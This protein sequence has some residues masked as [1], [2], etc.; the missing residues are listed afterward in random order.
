MTT[1]WDMRCL[2][3]TT[4]GLDPVEWTDAGKIRR[5]A[6]TKIERGRADEEAQDQVGTLVT[7]IDNVEGTY[8]PGIAPHTPVRL[9]I[10]RDSTAA[11]HPLF[12][13]LVES[14]PALWPAPGD[15]IVELSA[16]DGLSWLA[17]V[18][19][20]IER[21]DELPGDRIAAVLDAAGWP[22]H[23][24][25]LDPGVVRFAEGGR[26]IASDALSALREAVRVE[27]GQIFVAGDGTLTFRDR[28]ARLGAPQVARFGTGGLMMTDLS[29][30]YDDFK[31]YT[32]GRAE[33]ADG[34]VIK[35][36]SDTIDQFGRRTFEVRDLPVSHHEAVAAI[37]W[38]VVCYDEPTERIPRL[39]I[40]GTGD[41]AV[42]DVQISQ[43]LGDMV[44]IVHE[45][46]QLPLDVQVHIE[47]ETH[48]LMGGAWRTVYQLS[49]YFGAGPW[50]EWLADDDE[51]T[52]G[53]TWLSD[54]ATE[55]AAWA[56]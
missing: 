43:Q 23:L 47:R 2:L 40:N 36:E 20:D 27:Q 25:D 11:W 12:T 41:D 32:V 13:G 31:L 52:D 17:R 37:S 10:K 50:M 53:G 8:S 1:P 9:E 22:A 45:S 28:H 33:M 19:I 35:F 56:P 51:S 55:G 14:A 49:P 21:P 38:M 4:P 15:G 7:T 46:D 26:T 39:E 48:R 44:R 29:R 42:L 54:A 24:R 30:T 16:V 3:G 5:H 6:T 18:D 34:R